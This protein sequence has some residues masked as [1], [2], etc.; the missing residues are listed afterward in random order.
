MRGNTLARTAPAGGRKPAEQS[1]LSFFAQISGDE[2]DAP[3]LQSRNFGHS[4]FS[5]IQFVPITMPYSFFRKR[6]DK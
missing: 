6:R 4:P 3:T 2:A 5:A 1:L